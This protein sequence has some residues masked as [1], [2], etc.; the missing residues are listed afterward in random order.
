MDT[1]YS[2]NEIDV[3]DAHVA[4]CLR[5]ILS[6]IGVTDGGCAKNGMMM[7]IRKFEDTTFNDLATT[8]T[9]DRVIAQGGVG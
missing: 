2:E 9:R 4:G 1:K 6:I 7:W 5:A 3:C 8:R